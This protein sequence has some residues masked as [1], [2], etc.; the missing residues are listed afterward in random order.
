MTR[1]RLTPAERDTIVQLVA[2]GVTYREICLQLD[3]SAQTVHY[4]A[5]RAMQARRSSKPPAADRSAAEPPTPAAFMVP[6]P[7]WMEQAACI[8]VNPELFYP[9]KVDDSGP[10]KRVCRHCPVAAQCLEYALDIDDRWG[11]WGGTG[12]HIRA[13]LR[14]A[15]ATA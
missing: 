13:R 8:G 10:A 7:S 12:S 1:P 15:R 6:G 5:K 4:H 9:T 11:I 14:K 2:E 3:V